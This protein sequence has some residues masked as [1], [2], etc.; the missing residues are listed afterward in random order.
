MGC[1][2]GRTHGEADWLGWGDKGRRDKW[3][4]PPAWAEHTPISLP[5][6]PT[7]GDARIEEGDMEKRRATCI[8]GEQ[9][10]ET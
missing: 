5:G 4:E 2:S 1:Y 3:K 9:T 10:E 6:P 7:G 8:L